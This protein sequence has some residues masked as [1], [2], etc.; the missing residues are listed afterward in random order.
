L[1]RVVFEEV[2]EGPQPLFTELQVVSRSGGGHIGFDAKVA[3]VAAKTSLFL[4]GNGSYQTERIVQKW[5][6]W[7]L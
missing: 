2:E 1:V 6:A 3:Q 5:L 4:A 7:W